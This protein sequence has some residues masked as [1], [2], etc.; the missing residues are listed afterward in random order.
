MTDLANLLAGI[1]G[2]E[3]VV[4][5]AETRAPYEVDWMRRFQGT[6]KAVVSPAS[7]SEVAAVVRVCAASGAGVVAQGGNTGLVGGAVPAPDKTSVILRTHRLDSLEPVDEAAG[8]VT[9][10]AGVPLSRLQELAAKSGMRFA[11]DMASRGE[12]T[13]GGMVATNAGGLHVLAHGSMRAQ[14]LGVE[15]VLAG[16]EVVSR[17]G[18]LVKDNTG[19]DLAGLLTG[20]E[21]TLGVITQARLRLL[22]E[23]PAK[24]VA[25]IGVESLGQALTALEAVRGRVVGLEAAEVLFANGMDLAA[26]HLGLP[27]PLARSWPTYALFECAGATDPTPDLLATLSDLDLP[28]GALLVARDQ[29]ERAALWAYREDLPAAVGALGVVHKLDVAVP[30]TRLEAF[31][32]ALPGA[33]QD[34]APGS[35]LIVWGHLGDGNLHVNVLGPPPGEGSVDEAVLR[36][37]AAF[38][39]TISAEHGVGRAKVAWLG[40]ARSPAEIA[41]MRAIKAALDPQGVLNP[42]VLLATAD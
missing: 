12:A 11:V 39:G 19:Y 1:V 9:V 17:L 13:V 30:L 8:Q 28:E 37:A 33:L 16:G 38:Q 42:G 27:R 34:V 29:E 36:L 14:V 18:G 23:M 20:S 24:A 41:A 4:T 22:P 31:A 35:S 15:A 5:D 7:T 10:G 21:G 40:L 6:A 2:A 25:L 32:V 26:E 3:N